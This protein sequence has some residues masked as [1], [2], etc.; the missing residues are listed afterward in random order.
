MALKMVM[1][2]R[3]SKSPCSAIV[4]NKKGLMNKNR[5]PASMINGSFL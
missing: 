1:A 4:N 5:S 3:I 2:G